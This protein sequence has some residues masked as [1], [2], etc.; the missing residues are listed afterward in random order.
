MQ[1]TVK[2]NALQRLLTARG[3]LEHVISMVNSESYCIDIL[4]Q[5]LAVQAALKAVD[6]IILKGHLEEHATEA[7]KGK[8]PKK[9][10]DEIIEI[11]D[12]ARR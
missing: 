9:A 10:I 1:D 12:K 4:Q 8:D 3:H 5:S 7:L 6:H 2:E 11:F